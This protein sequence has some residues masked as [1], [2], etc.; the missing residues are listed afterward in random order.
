[1]KRTREGCLSGYMA[2]LVV[3][4]NMNSNLTTITNYIRRSSD[5]H[6]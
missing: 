4:P 1:M 6:V 5:H 2:I 3:P